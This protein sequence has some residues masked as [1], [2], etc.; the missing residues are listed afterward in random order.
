MQESKAALEKVKAEQCRCVSCG[1]CR[2]QGTIWVD[3]PEYPYDDIETCDECQGYGIVEKC[4]R[5]QLL[6]EMEF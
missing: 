4:D 3:V 5:C 2:G 6:D 1:I